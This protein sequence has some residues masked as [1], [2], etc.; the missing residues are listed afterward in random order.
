VLWG[1]DPG[2]NGD[3]CEQTKE[4]RVETEKVARQSEE[5]RKNRIGN[6][7]PFNFGTGAFPGG[8]GKGKRKKKRTKNL[9]EKKKER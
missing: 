5:V 6:F 2:R 8:Q 3:F 4:T 1:G 9:R 7:L